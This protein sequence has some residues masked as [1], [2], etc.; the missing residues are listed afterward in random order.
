M[1]FLLKTEDT[2]SDMEEREK[3]SFDFAGDVTK[4]LITLSIGILT[5]CIAFTDKIFSSEAA[6]ANSWLIFVALSLFTISVLCGILTLMKLTGTIARNSRTREQL[7]LNQSTPSRDNSNSANSNIYDAYTRIFSGMQMFSFLLA[8]IFSMAFVGCSLSKKLN[9]DEQKTEHI[10]SK[11]SI[12]IKV[13]CVCPATT[14]KKNFKRRRNNENE[15]CYKYI[16]INTCIDTI[17]SKSAI[18]ENRN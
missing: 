11:D 4:Q 8:I 9:V 14:I 17:V 10:P 12:F 16:K 6:H 13:E 2:D 3:K 15:S 5:L 18:G 1:A 7:I